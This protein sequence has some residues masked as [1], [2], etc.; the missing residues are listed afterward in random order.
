[1]TTHKEVHK[2]ITHAVDR[3]LEW[4]TISIINGMLKDLGINAEFSTQQQN[5][6]FDH[7]EGCLITLEVRE[8]N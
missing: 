4:N 2:Q 7:K 8:A 5:I 1:M 6:H 3:R